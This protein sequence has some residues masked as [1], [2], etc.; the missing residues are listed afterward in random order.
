MAISVCRISLS[1]PK[2]VE[3][4]GHTGTCINKNYIAGTRGRLR[5][6]NCRISAMGILER[7]KEIGVCDDVT[8]R[9]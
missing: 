1:E 9:A 6:H 5:P 4:D 3:I 8:Y 7:I 2:L